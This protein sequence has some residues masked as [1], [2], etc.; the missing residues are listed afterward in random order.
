MTETALRCVDTQQRMICTLCSFLTLRDFC[1]NI[2]P[3]NGVLF[4]YFSYEIS[5]TYVIGGRQIT[6]ID[7]PILESAQ[8]IG[9][10]ACIPA[11]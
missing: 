2:R 10:K 5:G 7:F 11:A 6:V 8:P 4:L 1:L 3:L 9:G